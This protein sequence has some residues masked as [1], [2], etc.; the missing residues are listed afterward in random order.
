[1]RACVCAHVCVCVCV[2]ACV[3]VCVYVERVK[4]RSGDVPYQDQ[5]R[6]E[7]E[8]GR[9]EREREMRACMHVCVPQSV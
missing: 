8:G 9:R 5:E 3:S 1:M 6:A 4:V 7:R 2:R